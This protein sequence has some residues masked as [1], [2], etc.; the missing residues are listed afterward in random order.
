MRGRRALAA[1]IICLIFLGDAL[2]AQ[3]A[4]TDDVSPSVEDAQILVPP[5]PPP[6]LLRIEIEGV[7]LETAE[8]VLFYGEDV[9]R[10]H[11]EGSRLIR[12]ERFFE[13]AGD[14]EASQRARTYRRV[15]RGLSTLA[16]MSFFSGLVLFSAGDD[17]DFTVLGFPDSM[18]GR[19]VSVSLI[20]G[21]LVPAISLVVRG[22]NWAPLSMSF[23]AMQTYNNTR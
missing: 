10:R 21:S 4:P 1:F 16:I 7:R 22:D 17:V 15:N 11:F 13:L 8:S 18:S 14:M 9:P 19:F 20:G 2:Q 5:P 23:N 3:N 12:E 6:L